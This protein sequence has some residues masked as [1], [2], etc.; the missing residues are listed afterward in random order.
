MGQ[1]YKSY[2]LLMSRFFPKGIID[3]EAIFRMDVIEK[4]A[5]KVTG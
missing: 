3:N 2:I 4:Q 5:L 1:R